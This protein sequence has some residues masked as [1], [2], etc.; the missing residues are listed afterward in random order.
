[1]GAFEYQGT[2]VPTVSAFTIGYSDE[3]DTIVNSLTVAFSEPVML[4]TLSL[5]SS[6]GTAMPF[7]LT[8]SDD[9]TYVL[10]FPSSLSSSYTGSALPS[11]DY[12]LIV[13]P[14]ASSLNGSEETFNFASA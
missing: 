7:T 3:E 10:T 14:I 2:A 1:M 12:M 4:G 8:T 9:Q 11:G 5:Y 6:N 13:T